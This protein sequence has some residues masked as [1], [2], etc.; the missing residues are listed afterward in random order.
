MGHAAGDGV[1]EG[2]SLL[3]DGLHD[4]GVVVTEGTGPPAGDYINVAIALI[5]EEIDAFAADDVRK[6]AGLDGGEGGVGMKEVAHGRIFSKISWV[7]D[8][9]AEGSLEKSVGVGL[10]SSKI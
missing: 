8:C 9:T 5:V 1:L 10:S 3:L 4:L 7:S 2:S 6:V